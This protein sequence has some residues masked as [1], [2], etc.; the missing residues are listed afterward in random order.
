MT[1]WIM[2]KAM[3][4]L[5]IQKQKQKQKTKFRV[6]FPW[7]YFNKK[8]RTFLNLNYSDAE[9]WSQALNTSAVQ[10]P[11]PLAL[12]LVLLPTDCC[13][14]PESGS[15]VAKLACRSLMESPGRTRQNMGQAPLV[16]EGRHL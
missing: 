9:L 15:R 2:I 1:V 16:H 12:R 10:L 11:G 14:C 5:T 8:K 13:I 7:L 6:K 3:D 4:K